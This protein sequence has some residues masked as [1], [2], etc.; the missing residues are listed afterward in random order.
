MVV[1][2]V[3]VVVVDATV[4]YHAIAAFLSAS[5]ALRH[6]ATSPYHVRHGGGAQAVSSLGQPNGASPGG[7]TGGGVGVGAG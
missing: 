4:A 3:V 6:F 7:L 2:V 1:V 5:V